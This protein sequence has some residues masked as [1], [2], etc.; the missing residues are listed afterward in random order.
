MIEICNKIEPRLG[1]DQTQ[2]GVLVLVIKAKNKKI[3]KLSLYKTGTA[4]SMRIEES[5]N[6]NKTNHKYENLINIQPSVPKPLDFRI[7]PRKKELD[8]FKKK[9]EKQKKLLSPRGRDKESPYF[10]R[11]KV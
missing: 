10:R 4:Q 9:Y 3:D 11:K 8:I 1:F 2:Y 6:S 5:F 7:S